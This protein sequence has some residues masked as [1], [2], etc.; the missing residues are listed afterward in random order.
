MGLTWPKVQ[1]IFPVLYRH[2]GFR[3]MAVTLCVVFEWVVESAGA[4]SSCF[5][6]WSDGYFQGVKHASLC[7]AVICNCYIRMLLLLLSC[8]ALVELFLLHM[9]RHDVLMCLMPGPST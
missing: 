1:T 3:S 2:D 4:C 6:T 9:R 8:K 7:R 5:S